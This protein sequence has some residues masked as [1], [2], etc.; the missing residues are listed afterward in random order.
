[1]AEPRSRIWCALGTFS[2]PTTYK[3]FARRANFFGYD[4]AE[5]GRIQIGAGVRM[6][7]TVSVR[8][9][10]RIRIGAGAHVGQ[11]CY[12]W[13]GDNVGRIEIGDHALLAPDVMLT[14]S[15]YDF[16]AGLGPVMDLPKREADIR[17]GANTWLGAKVVVVAG[18]MVGDGT[19]VAAGSVV[20]KS[21][22][23]N[24]VAA[25]VP[26]KVLRAR[27]NDG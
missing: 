12:L 11:G 1:V 8:N 24:V 10:E 17:I 26:A 9:G 20:T 19:I 7:P 6:S 2:S 27:G 25:G 14:A 3:N 5:Q 13:A 4:V 18:V 22:P 21:L 23:A 16:D 15:N